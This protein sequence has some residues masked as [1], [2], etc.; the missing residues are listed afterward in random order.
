MPQHS[1]TTIGPIDANEVYIRVGGVERS[2][3]QDSDPTTQVIGA[4]RAAATSGGSGNKETDLN[5][6]SRQGLARLLQRSA[7]IT[8]QEAG[9]LAG[10]ILERRK[11]VAIFGS[12]DE[13]A[14]MAGM[15]PAALEQLRQGAFAGPIAVR[16]QDFIGPAIG[17][18]LKRKAGLAILGS[19]VGMLVY[20]WIRFKHVEW[21]LA[22]VVALT[23]D[24]LIVLGL[25]AMFG[26]EMSLPVVAAFLTLVGYSVNDTVVVFDRIRENLRSQPG[27]SLESLVNLSINQTLSRTIITSGLTLVAVVAL[28]AYGGAALNPFSFVLTAG[29]IV[30]TYSSIYIASPFLVLW[31]RFVERRKPR[32]AEG[33]RAGGRPRKV[34]AS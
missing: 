13:L 4:L 11:E 16:S 6:V 7:G 10:A 14:D 5:A 29:V 23:H 3:E 25:F 28:L 8:A 19:L 18:E 20:I 22:A 33:A 27:K 9:D 31:R 1:V 30:G 15:T 21:G 12:V 32:G 24:T 26:K 17:A 2:E 34:R